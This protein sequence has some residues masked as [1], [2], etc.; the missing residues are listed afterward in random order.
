MN[1]LDRFAAPPRR[2]AVT[3]SPYIWT[4]HGP[5]ASCVK[6]KCPTVPQ[7]HPNAGVTSN[8]QGVGGPTPSIGMPRSN[9]VVFG[10]ECEV[11]IVALQ[12]E[13][14]ASVLVE[15]PVDEEVPAIGER[16]GE[17]GEKPL[18]IGSDQVA[19]YVGE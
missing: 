14:G 2:L 19:V 11:L 3:D 5:C 18:L 4:A 16:G 13:A 7:N 6:A 17:V 12:A 10:D 8:A 9:G 15:A 1:S